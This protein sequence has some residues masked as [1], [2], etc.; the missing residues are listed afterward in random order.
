MVIGSWPCSTC[1]EAVMP[2][3]LKAV[4]ILSLRRR[5]PCF[6]L[7]WTP[8]NDLQF[9]WPKISFFSLASLKFRDCIVLTNILFFL[10]WIFS[11]KTLRAKFA[12]SERSARS[13]ARGTSS[14]ITTFF[15]SSGQ[16]SRAFSAILIHFSDDLMASLCCV[17]VSFMSHYRPNMQIVMI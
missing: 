7:G 5:L 9:G 15:S 14:R 12:Y 10:I 6:P 8:S 2:A 16:S 17:D 4:I 11:A 1:L 3:Y 13:S